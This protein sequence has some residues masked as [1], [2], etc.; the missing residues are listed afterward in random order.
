MNRIKVLWCAILG[1]ALAA[2]FAIAL[3]IEMPMI[4]SILAAIVILGFSK[5]EPGREHDWLAF[6]ATIAGGLFIQL[7]TFL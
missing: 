5:K 3:P 4:T 2:I 1:L 6:G 7:L